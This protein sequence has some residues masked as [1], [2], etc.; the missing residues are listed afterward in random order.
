MPYGAALAD[1]VEDEKEFF[2]HGGTLSA[3]FS[4]G[5]RQVFITRSG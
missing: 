5:L 4:Y 2:L 3:S 1:L